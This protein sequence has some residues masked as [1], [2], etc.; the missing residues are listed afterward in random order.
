[1]SCPT[2]GTA[3][4]LRTRLDPSNIWRNLLW[5]ALAIFT[6]LLTSSPVRLDM[7]EPSWQNRAAHLQV[8]EVSLNHT[9]PFSFRGSNNAG[10]N[11]RHGAKVLFGFWPTARPTGGPS[12]RAHGLPVAG[13]QH[14]ASSDRRHAA[15]ACPV[16]HLGPPSVYFVLLKMK[17]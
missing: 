2:L 13:P 8:T 16:Q 4:N 5:R 7:P 15:G 17:N 12:R 11:G 3:G 1:M 9:H 6:C 14:A 10:V